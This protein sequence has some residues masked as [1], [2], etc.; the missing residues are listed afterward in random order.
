MEI[1]KFT[2]NVK[3]SLVDV[4]KK[5]DETDSI[6]T[7]FVLN[8]KNK[9]L[10]TITDGDIRRAFINGLTLENPLIDFM[11]KNFSY[12]ESNNKDFEKLKEFRDAKIKAVPILSDTGEILKIID[13]T[14]TKSLLPVDAV[15]MAGGLGSRLKPLTDNT[16]KPLLKV[17]NKEII[18]YNFDRL[19]QYGIFNQNITVNYLGDQIE[20]YCTD[21]NNNI[22]F[23]VIKENKFLG[24]AGSLSLIDNFEND[25]ILLMNSDLL[26]NIDYEDFYKSFRDSNA[27]IMV[28]S[29]PYDISLPYAIFEIENNRN[30]KSFKEKPAFTHYANTGIYLFKKNVLKHIPKNTFYN[31][32]DL[33]NA[34]INENGKLIHFPITGYWLDIGK[35]K[36]FEKAQ[37]DISHI[38][39]N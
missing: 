25:T 39:F 11:Y 18:S 37:R 14:V 26:T 28:A 17:G 8:D 10:G 9:L 38:D 12:L 13:F 3:S 19:Y 33:M 34:V 31:A 6:Q 36:D 22:N 2:I 24:T 21:Y 15:I 32:T 20:E 1:N 29:I 7:V 27:D 4:L 35:L 23:N 16:P 5:I 30:I